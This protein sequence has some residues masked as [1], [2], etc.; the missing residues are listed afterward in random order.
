MQLNPI[1]ALELRARWRMNR[2]HLL[3]LGVVLALSFLAAFVYQSAGLR[4]DNDA[5]L[6]SAS[7]LNPSAALQSFNGGA[8]AIGRQL[9]MAIAHA[10]ILSWLLLSVASAATGI[11]RERERGLLESLQLSHMSAPDQIR[12]RFFANVLLLSLLQ[13]VLLPVYC[14]AMMMGGVSVSEVAGA[15]YLATCAAILGTAIGLWFSARS[16]R[17][18]NA[19]F[20]SLSTILLLSVGLFYWIQDTSMWASRFGRSIHWETLWP[21]LLHPSGLFWALTDPMPKW[22]WSPLEMVV[23]AG[24]LWT[25]SSLLLLSM[26]ARNV[27]RSLPV[28]AW[29]TGSVWVEK[30]KQK[31]VAAPPKSVRAQRTNDALLAD[32]PLD[33]F[34]K[35][36]DP[37]LSREVKSRFRLRRAGFWLSVVR[38]ALFLG[39]AAAWLFEVFWL[40]DPPSRNQ[41]APYGLRVLLYGGT[42]CLAVL[43]ATSWTRERES[44]TWES[45]K[46][47]LLTPRQILRAKW[48]SPLISFAY[49]SAPLWVLLP[50]GALFIN[51]NS[52]AAGVVVVAAWLGLA[53]ALGLW[54]S[55]RVRNGTAAIAWTV[56]VLALLLIAVPWLNALAGVD[57]TLAS[58]KYGVGNPVEIYN[59]IYMGPPN[60]AALPRFA[61]IYEQ[62][63]GAKATEIFTNNF[64]MAMGSYYTPGLQSWVRDKIGETDKFKRGLRVWHPG[65]ALERLFRDASSRDNLSYP[66]Y[67][68]NETNL[69]LAAETKSAVLWSVLSPF[70][71]TMILLLLLRRDVKR[72]QLN[73]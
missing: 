11:A 62:Q 71:L 10:N 49:Y 70:F 50:I 8:S 2:S 5:A 18:T 44:G 7:A 17:P 22:T 31:Q 27:N 34:V 30:L 66:Y 33:R 56:G 19:L 72:E 55:W 6:A 1:L 4:N 54:M 37:L 53:V 40:F 46:L 16:H 67:G 29:R 47:S 65:E 14:V 45:L 64:G 28:A 42:L 43:A 13:L 15:I 68:N 61:K 39:A 48:L 3:L 32:I 26:A 36:A 59:A 57:D 24:A 41:M 25:L 52:F 35:F 20:G 63:S 69:D 60:S 38:G 12:A 21:M 23:G 58:W 51:F 9:F 73:A